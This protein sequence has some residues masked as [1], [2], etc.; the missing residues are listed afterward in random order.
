MSLG[1]T[2]VIRI[3]RRGKPAGSGNDATAPRRR[4]TDRFL[5]AGRI[6]DP[7][8]GQAWVFREATE[9]V[10]MLCEPPARIVTARNRKRG[11]KP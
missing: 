5:L 10:A 11:K 9:L 4:A 6:E 2:Y 3:Y 7:V 8:S 1:E